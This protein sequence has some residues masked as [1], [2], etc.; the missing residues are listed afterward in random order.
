MTQ[1][2][3]GGQMLYVGTIARQIE[4]PDPGDPATVVTLFATVPPNH[5]YAMREFVFRNGKNG[6]QTV[7]FAKK[8]I[9][10]RVVTY[11]HQASVAALTSTRV[12]YDEA[13]STCNSQ[14]LPQIMTPGMYC[15]LAVLTS[16]AAHTAFVWIDV[17]R[18][19]GTEEVLP[20]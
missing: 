8:D 13:G 20:V 2:L 1:A 9:Q 4:I 6:A 15:Y 7:Y 17:Y 3:N 19:K 12:L 14:P 16:D 5:I 11:W 10:D 18:W